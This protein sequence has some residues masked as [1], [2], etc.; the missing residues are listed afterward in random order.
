M[1]LQCTHCGASYTVVGDEE[2]GRFRS[3]CECERSHSCDRCKRGSKAPINQAELDN[4]DEVRRYLC[5][6]HGYFEAEEFAE[7]TPAGPAPKKRTVVEVVDKP[8]P[9]PIHPESRSG[10]EVLE[11]LRAKPP[12]MKWGD[13]KKKFLSEKPPKNKAEGERLRCTS[14]GNEH[15][16]YE[17]K[18]VADDDAKCIRILCPKC[19]ATG[20][21]IL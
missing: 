11:H 15:W 18:C 13:F 8:A 2:T 17:R 4:M 20:Y 6:A 9:P 3:L 19:E 5:R 10:M 1:S 16:H 21:T 14:C 12:E 7:L